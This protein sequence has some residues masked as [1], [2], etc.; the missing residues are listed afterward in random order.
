MFACSSPVEAD[1]LGIVARGVAEV[2]LLR[3]A[4]RR[5]AWLWVWRVS[6]FIPGSLL[7]HQE[8]ST[9]FPLES[10]G[11]LSVRDCGSDCRRKICVPTLSEFAR[12]YS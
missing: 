7:L 9:A 8:D 2:P 6:K 4:S 1:Y 3:A 11:S 5:L 10:L 12:M